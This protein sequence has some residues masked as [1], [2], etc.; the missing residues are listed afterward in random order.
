MKKILLAILVSVL[1]VVSCDK[2]NYNSNDM[3]TVSFKEQIVTTGV[4]TRAGD[5]IN[6]I[7]EQTPE[8][9]VITLKNLDL[10]ETFVCNSN[11]DITIPVGEY[12]IS[13]ASQL[14][15]SMVVGRS[16]Y[17]YA[18]PQLRSDAVTQT[19]TSNTTSI[20]LNVYY[21]CYAVIASKDECDKCEIHYS[22]NSVREMFEYGDHFVSYF[23]HDDVDIVIKP[24]ADSTRLLT[25][26][27]TFSTD[28]ENGKV[29]AE[30]GKFYAIHP[31]RI[32][33]TGSS[34]DFVLDGMT[35]GNI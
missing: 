12:V 34:F 31:K 35:E 10:N 4:M 27:F 14:G 21:D 16:Q 13:S 20:T 23:K 7:K 1:F 32:G 5:F 17:M 26:T 30:Q 18:S 15:D 28:V 3:V 33:E 2:A 29:F 19:I 22:D 24:H 11:E 6:T 25:T 9:V 8:Y